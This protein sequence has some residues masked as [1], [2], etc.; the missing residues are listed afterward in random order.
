MKKNYVQPNVN[1]V[2]IDLKQQVLCGSQTSISVYID[3]ETDTEDPQL[4][5]GLHSLWEDEQE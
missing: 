2:D 3:E 5:R 4:A 1:I